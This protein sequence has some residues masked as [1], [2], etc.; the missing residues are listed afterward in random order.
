MSDAVPLP[1]TT[2]HAV[3]EYLCVA[4]AVGAAVDPVDFTLPVSDDARRSVDRLLANHQVPAGRPLIVVNP[5]A[6]RS[7]KHWPSERWSELLD[8]LADAGTILVIGTAPQVAAHQAITQQARRRPID[9]TGRTTLAEMIA[10]LDRAALHLAP[11]TGTVHVA[12][13]LGTPVVAIYGPTS[14]VRVG[15][16]RHP[17]SVM[18]HDQLCGRGCPAY[19]VYG[20]R[21]LSAVTTAEVLDKAL[22]AISGGGR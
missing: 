17:E 13:A 5:S 14:R 19:C 8:A 1:A 2:V 11:D 20:R 4:R 15:P 18:A 10:L 21:C 6:A 16:Y 7:W 22:A 9:L 12:V 3:D